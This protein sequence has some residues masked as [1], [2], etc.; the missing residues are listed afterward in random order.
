[1]KEYITFAK[2]PFESYLDRSDEYTTESFDDTYDELC[3][4]YIESFN[5]Y[6]DECDFYQEG[7]ILDYAKGVDTDNNKIVTVLLFIPRLIIALAKSIYN[8][9]TGKNNQDNVKLAEAIATDPE[10]AMKEMVAEDLEDLSDRIGT[11]EDYTADNAH[12]LMGTIEKW[13]ASQQSKPNNNDT[14]SSNDTTV[15]TTPS[16]PDN[17]EST[18]KSSE[19]VDYNGPTKKDNKTKKLKGTFKA[20][21]P[22]TALSIGVDTVYLKLLESHCDKIDFASRN[23]Y[24]VLMS[25]VRDSMNGHTV[26]ASDI[27][28]DLQ[29]DK[30]LTITKKSILGSQNTRIDTISK[31][32]LRC[33]KHLT[34]SIKAAKNAEADFRNAK[35]IPVGSSPENAKHVINQIIVPFF[36]AFTKYSNNVSTCVN[37]A[38]NEFNNKIRQNA[39]EIAKKQSRARF[40]DQKDIREARRRKKKS[41]LATNPNNTADKRFKAGQLGKTKPKY[42]NSKHRGESFYDDFDENESVVVEYMI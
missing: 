19:L 41:G 40:T 2:D 33:R 39:A 3:E 16:T 15:D 10:K 21:I 20:L 32:L 31:H 9:I 26:K 30:K 35:D 34:N 29:L 28:G 5:Q 36:A 37:D 27:T 11:L 13:M 17:P 6:L 18:E 24:K 38:L 42:N 4:L 8:K 12:H 25:N 14:G 23:L 7:E 22:A 1:M